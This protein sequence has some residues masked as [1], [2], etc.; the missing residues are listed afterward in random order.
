[1]SVEFLTEYFVPVIAGIVLCICFMIRKTTDKLDRYIPLIAGVLGTLAA[2]WQSQF[3]L[4]PAI[5]L[6]GLFSGLAATGLYEMLDNLI[7]KK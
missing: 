5:L 7:N 6:T 3:K 4:D 1:M 2:F